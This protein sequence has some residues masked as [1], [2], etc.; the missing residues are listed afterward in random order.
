MFS[1]QAS[2]QSVSRGQSFWICSGICSSSPQSQIAKRPSHLRCLF[3]R[4]LFL[5][6]SPAWLILGLQLHGVISLPIISLLS[7]V[8]DSLSGCSNLGL[9]KLAFPCKLVCP[10]N[11]EEV[12]LC[13]ICALVE[14]WYFVI[15]ENNLVIVSTR[16]YTVRTWIH[17]AYTPMDLWGR[18]CVNLITRNEPLSS[19]VNRPGP[20]WVL[21]RSE[22]SL[23]QAKQF[24]SQK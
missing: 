13:E 9:R 1:G 18:Y 20:T 22:V 21:S 15:K 14:K 5:V 12:I 19:Q 6:F 10:F 2:F 24:L 16:G 17:P 11:S 3:K 4:V 7:S 8:F 23:Q